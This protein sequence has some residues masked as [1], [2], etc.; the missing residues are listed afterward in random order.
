MLG[1]GLLLQFSNT[2]LLLGVILS[3]CYV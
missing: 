2:P 1:Y 3:W